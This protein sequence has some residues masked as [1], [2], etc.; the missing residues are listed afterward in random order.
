M[1]YIKTFSQLLEKNNIIE[2]ESN[3]NLKSTLINIFRIFKTKDEL[4]EIFNEQDELII[5]T[6]LYDAFI[7]T[8]ELIELNQEE[9]QSFA[10]N[11][12]VGGEID[13][14]I[15]IISKLY[16][17]KFNRNIKDDIIFCVDIIKEFIM[18]EESSERIKT[19]SKKYLTELEK[20]KNIL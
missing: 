7:D 20:I 2:Q 5:A 10:D 1:K 11:L 9:L 3:I 14:L 18:T 19:V 15:S 4:K 13:I 6:D 12:G 17:E 8:K 16:N